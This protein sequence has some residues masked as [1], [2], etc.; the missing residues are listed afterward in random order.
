MATV[1]PD[2]IGT[3]SDDPMIVNLLSP[4][5]MCASS[6]PVPGGSIGILRNGCLIPKRLWKVF[7][8]MSIFHA[9]S[10]RVL[11][12]TGLMDHQL[13]DQLKQLR[14]VPRKLSREKTVYLLW[15]AELGLLVEK[16]DAVH[17][18]EATFLKLYGEQISYSLSK[19]AS[20]DVLYHL[21]LLCIECPDNHIRA[22]CCSLTWLKGILNLWPGKICGHGKKEITSPAMTVDGQ[23][24]LKKLLHVTC[25]S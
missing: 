25:A 14:I 2:E 5:L 16:D 22:I 4:N 8:A 11:S 6:V 10:M 20:L 9:S 23:C 7:G 15:G 19:N 13:L 3:V 18:R 21:C 17:V 1:L 12:T 24:I